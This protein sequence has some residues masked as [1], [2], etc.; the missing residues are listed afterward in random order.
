MAEARRLKHRFGGA[1]RQA[2]IIAAAGVY[3][4]R[5]NV[6]RMADDH[7]NARLLAEGLAEIPGIQC[8]PDDIETNIVHFDVSETGRTGGEINDAITERGV[9]MGGGSGGRM[10]AVTH[11]DI[12]RADIERAVEAMREA[13]LAG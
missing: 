5:H 13:V 6:D 12:S 3:A 9:R 2:G 10:R 1:M 7:A 8:S 11:L 4:L